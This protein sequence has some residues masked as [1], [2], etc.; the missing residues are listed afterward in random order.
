MTCGLSALRNE[1]VSNSTEACSFFKAPARSSCHEDECTRGMGSAGPCQDETAAGEGSGLAQEHESTMR[2][3]TTATTC[4][5]RR[6]PPLVEGSKYTVLAQNMTHHGWGTLA[7]QSPGT[8]HVTK[9][10]QKLEKNLR[11][12]HLHLSR[13]HRL[14]RARRTDEF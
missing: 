3:P 1:D 14:E 7:T 6:L 9:G 5:Y 10:G 11:D 4:G 13:H 12:R 2:I 8:R